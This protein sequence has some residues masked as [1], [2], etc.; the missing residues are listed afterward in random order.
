MKLLAFGEVLWDVYPQ[1]RFIGGA[2]L[3]FA[4]H[5]AKHGIDA[6][7]L[8]AVGDDELG[9]ETLA[10]L[11]NWGLHTDYVSVLPHKQTGKCLVTLDENSIPSYDLLKDV[12]WDY[13]NCKTATENTFDVLYFGTLAL[14]SENNK[15]ALKALINSS[16]FRHIF[17]DVNIR[18]PFYSRES[19]R[20]ALE[21]ATIVKISDEELPTVANTLDLPLSDDHEQNAKVLAARFPGLQLV[22]ITLGENGSCA[23]DVAADTFHRQGPIQTEVVSTVG[24][25]DSFGAAFLSRFWEGLSIDRCLE[26]AAKVAAF[27]VS[28]FDAIPD[29]EP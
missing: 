1:E 5:C 27:V 9:K 17:V 4:A 15:A 10:Q 6:Y 18:P 8:S 19:I 23:Y 16:S 26:Y 7:M 14:R 12:A 11:K 3:N 2:P 21:N 28:R 13:V 25:G 20:F 29:Y 22:L 24:A